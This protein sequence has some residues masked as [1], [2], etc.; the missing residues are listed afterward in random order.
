M[1]K[2]TVVLL[3]LLSSS[4]GGLSMVQ[5]VLSGDRVVLRDGRVIRYAGLQGPAPGDPWHDLARGANAYLVQDK[6]VELRI[7]PDIPGEEGEIVAFVYTPVSEG[8]KTRYLF[9]NAELVRFGL[10]RA[11]P[12]PEKAVH[13]VLWQNLL[14][15]QEKEAKPLKRGMW[16]E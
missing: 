16:A 11:T 14:D 12:I 3:C 10:A 7:E 2:Y 8:G 5:K 6:V 4:C 13:Q 1:V 15:L 9:V